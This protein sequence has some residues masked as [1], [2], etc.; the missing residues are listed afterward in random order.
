[1]PSRLVNRAFS[2][3]FVLAA[4][5]VGCGEDGPSCEDMAQEF[6]ELLEA[7]QSCTMN[8]DC[9]AGPSLACFT[10][11]GII[12]N[13][14]SRDDF[15]ARGDEL[16]DAYM[17]RGCACAMPLCAE[18]VPSHFECVEHVCTSVADDI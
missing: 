3:L 11:C 13:R 7:N 10:G 12:V 18:E 9:V 1:M 2:A 15:R 5:A 14:S 8:A 4:L 6:S 17:D 16:V